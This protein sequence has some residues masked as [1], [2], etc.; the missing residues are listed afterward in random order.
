MRTSLVVQKKKNKK[1]KWS[2]IKRDLHHSK[3]SSKSVYKLYP[4]ICF[5]ILGVLAIFSDTIKDKWKL[6]FL[7]CVY[8]RQG[9]QYHR[10]PLKEIYV[11]V[12]STF[13]VTC[14]S[15]TPLFSTQSNNK[16]KL[17]SKATKSIQL[18]IISKFNRYF[19]QNWSN[20][21]ELNF[22]LILQVTNTWKGVFMHCK[23]NCL[24]ANI[25]ETETEKWVL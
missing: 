6:Q 4:L 17:W 13:D 25:F 15:W 3:F 24:L 1:Q 8:R 16:K 21:Y 12:F 10:R 11:K 19:L 7:C 22:L 9:V 5:P 23:H 2:A 20:S 18:L 14:L